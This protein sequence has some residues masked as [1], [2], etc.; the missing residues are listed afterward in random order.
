MNDRRQI[1]A[2]AVIILFMAVTIGHVA[3]YTGGFEPLG[4]EWLGFFY[5]LAVDASIAVCAWL[6]RWKTT[7]RWAW[8]GYVAFTIASGVLNIAHIAPRAIGAWVY[9]VFPTLAIALLGFLARDGA[10]SGTF[11]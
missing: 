6:T 1:A 5:A 10:A 2:Y 11:R 3:S 4:Q 9:A 7:E 8:L